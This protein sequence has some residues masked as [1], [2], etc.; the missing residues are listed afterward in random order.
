MSKIL[1]ISTIILIAAFQCYWISRLY[2]DEWMT[3]KK[4]TDLLFRDVVYKLQL[5]RFRSDS[6][7]FKKGMPDNLFAFNVIDSVREKIIDSTLRD[8]A[9]GNERHIFLSIGDE[10]HR[11]PLSGKAT[12]GTIVIRKDDSFNMPFPPPGTPP[13]IIQYF[14]TDKKINDSL[15]VKRIDSAYTT[16]LKK[17]NIDVPFIITVVTSKE[18]ELRNSVKPDELKTNFTFVGLTNAYA[19]QAEFASPFSYVIGKIK[20]Q[21][22]ISFLLLAITILSF[23]FLYRNLL[24]QRRLAEIK[25]EFISNITHELKTPIATVNV[26]IEALQK[27]N[28]IQNPERTKEYLEISA[29]E[30]QRLS[31]LVDKVLRLSM[32]ENSEI[33]LNKEYFDLKQLAQEVISTMKLQTGKLN[34]NIELVTDDNSFTVH[35]DKLHFTSVLYNLLDNAL[36][37]SREKIDIKVIL[38]RNDNIITLSVKDNG[39]GIAAEYKGKIF[40][41]FFRVPNSDKHNIKGYGLGLSYVRNIIMRHLGFIYV[42]TELGKGSTFVIKFPVEEASVI[43]FDEHRMIRKKVITP[44]LFKKKRKV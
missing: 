18:N 39:I 28:A 14:S 5:Q 26:A 34:A 20:F 41:K 23:L 38:Q 17:N 16:D 3:L 13:R 1:M 36:K 7:F 6:T 21:I 15:P 12:A 25:N 37:Y 42:E 44:T 4:E 9:S 27:F 8:S 32:F 29:S 33:K 35:A 11:D 22:L 2:N 43:R 24:A 30:L 31:M 40:D 19:Y 10:V